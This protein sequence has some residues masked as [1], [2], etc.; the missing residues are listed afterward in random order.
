MKNFNSKANLLFLLCSLALLVLLFSKTIRQIAEICLTQDDYSHGIL[1]P[2]IAAYSLWLK[3]KRI[4]E[5]VAP[6][7]LDRSFN[8]E[9]SLS[10]YFSYALLILGVMIYFLGAAS[11]M[12]HAT[13]IAFFPI[14]IAVVR[15][16]LG[17]ELSA[18]FL[19]P[20]LIQLMAKPLPD[21]VVLRI[22]WPLQVLAARISTFVLE[23][24]G[25][26]VYLVGNIIE[27]PQMRLLVEEACSG[28]RSVISLI[29]VALIVGHLFGM[30]SIA[31]VILLTASVGIAIGFNV[32]RVAMTGILAHFYDPAAASGFFHE[33]S[34][35][36]V[37]V[38][39][40]GLVYWISSLLT[41]PRFIQED[42]H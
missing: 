40:L 4:R 24:L 25:V 41:G 36:I 2:F 9:T 21:S 27:I 28:M 8:Q 32:L 18:I 3:R 6:I 11:G 33:F 31:R 5:L 35:M 42:V 38:I 29:T 12:L 37:F 17:K 23:I 15:L 34:G 16:T 7:Q 22:F 26:P 1:L 20:I 19:F 13:W 10:V 14:S 30:K 39:G